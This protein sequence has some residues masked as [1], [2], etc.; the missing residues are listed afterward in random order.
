MS[1]RAIG[2][3]LLSVLLQ[4]CSAAVVIWFLTENTSLDGGE[5]TALAAG[6]VVPVLL[7]TFVLIGLGVYIYQLQ[8][9]NVEKEALLNP[10]GEEEVQKAAL[11]RAKV[12]V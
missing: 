1:G 8:S 5:V 2:I 11:F 9:S 6:S 12:N 4:V 7:V 10:T 3:V